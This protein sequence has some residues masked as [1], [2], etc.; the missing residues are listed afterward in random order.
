M[1]LKC[2]NAWIAHLFYLYAWIIGDYFLNLQQIINSK[3]WNFGREI[4]EQVLD[5]L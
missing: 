2:L 3:Q 4:A 5:M 1:G